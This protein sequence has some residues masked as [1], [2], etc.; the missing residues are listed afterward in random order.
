MEPFPGCCTEDSGMYEYHDSQWRDTSVLRA[1]DLGSHPS[2]NAEVPCFIG[3]ILSAPRAV[4]HIE[5]CYMVHGK[6]VK[7]VRVCKS[8]GGAAV[9]DG[10]S[11]HRPACQMPLLRPSYGN[12]SICSAQV[13]ILGVV[14]GVQ[15]RARSSVL[16]ID[17]G[18]GTIPCLLTVHEDELLY[19]KTRDP[20]RGF[21]VLCRPSSESRCRSPSSSSP[22]RRSSS[23]VL[24]PSWGP[25]SA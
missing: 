22:H 11:L 13:E 1:V 17:D 10:F 8:P 4:K 20:V 14:V 12:A 15:S 9:G 6:P 21:W 2:F 24:R 7:K 19:H 5:G 18:T 16:T 23:S 3:D 25:W